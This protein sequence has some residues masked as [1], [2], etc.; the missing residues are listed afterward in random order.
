[1]EEE[2]DLDSMI[3]NEIEHEYKTLR[4]IHEDLQTL[5]IEVGQLRISTRLK[6][7][8]KYN[9]VDLK[10]LDF[11]IVGPKPLAYKKKDGRT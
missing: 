11:P 1:M 8:R 6:S 9:L 2:L 10:I 3:L 5:G 7:L 4:R